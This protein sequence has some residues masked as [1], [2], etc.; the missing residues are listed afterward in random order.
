LYARGIQVEAQTP[1]PRSFPKQR[2]PHPSPA[3]PGLST[4]SRPKDLT[5]YEQTW[6]VECKWWR[7]AVSKV[8]VAALANIVQ[9]VGA[10]RGILLTETGFQTGATRLA[11]LSNI[12][13]T[14]LT[15]WKESVGM[16]FHEDTVVEAGSAWLACTACGMVQP[17][18]W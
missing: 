13:L 6:I 14:S 5:S 11:S 12:T 7:R 16:C 15:E 3:L 2:R 10:D 9:D 17:T 8:H 4:S 1:L 18:D